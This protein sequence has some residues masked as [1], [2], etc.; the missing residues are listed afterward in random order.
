[1]IQK[2]IIPQQDVI[3]FVDPFQIL[4]CQSD[5]CYVSIYLSDG[6]RHLVVKSLSKFSKELSP[7]IFIRVNQ[8]FVVN[9]TY[10]TSIDKRKRSIKLIQDH[11]IPFTVTIKELMLM[12]STDYVKSSVGE[13]IP[14]V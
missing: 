14:N 12:I 1:M 11:D 3:H 6:R 13:E 5:S 7:E 10:I 8:S 4:F 2:I 9:K